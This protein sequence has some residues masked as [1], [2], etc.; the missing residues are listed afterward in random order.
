MRELTRKES[1]L[2]QG[3]RIQRWLRKILGIE[4]VASD[5]AKQFCRS[6]ELTV[7]PLEVEVKDLARRVDKLDKR[8]E[9]KSKLTVIKGDK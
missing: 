8:N 7:Y 5:L 9:V 6:V 1:F 4:S 3:N 2:P